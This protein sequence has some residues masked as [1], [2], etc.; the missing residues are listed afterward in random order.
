MPDSSRWARKTSGVRIVAIRRQ[1]IVDP[2]LRFELPKDYTGFE[3]WSTKDIRYMIRV[4][5][6]GQVR[7][8]VLAMGR[9][10][11]ETRSRMGCAPTTL[12]TQAKAGARDAEPVPPTMAARDHSCDRDWAWEREWGLARGA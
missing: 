7:S 3:S 5:P 1:L 11:T 10:I 6:P 4:N 9:V 2:M 8:A 12:P